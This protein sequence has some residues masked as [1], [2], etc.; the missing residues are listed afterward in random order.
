MTMTNLN[1]D[2]LEDVA[3]L[4]AEIVDEER[5]YLDSPRGKRDAARLD[6]EIDALVAEEEA[7][8]RRANLRRRGAVAAAEFRVEGVDPTTK[9]T[10]STV[11]VGNEPL[12]YGP[13]SDFSYFRDRFSAL[14]AVT[15]AIPSRNR[16][17][18]PQAVRD[19]LLRH[20]DQMSYL[21]AHGT[22]EERALL[23]GYF[24][25]RNRPFHGGPSDRSGED[26]RNLLTARFERRGISTL[27]ASMGDFAPTVFSLKDWAKYRTAGSPV[28]SQAGQSD[29]P[30]TGMT[31]DIPVMQGAVS[32][33]VQASENTA[34]DNSSPTVG[35]A[36]APVLTAAGVVELSQ[37]SLDRFGPGVRADEVIAAQAARQAAT[38]ID[39]QAVAAVFTSPAATITNSNSP[40]VGA[41]FA[42]VGKAK[43]IISTTEGVR[44][45]AT[46]VMI[47]PSNMAWFQSQLDGQQRP[48][49]GPSPAATLGHVGKANARDEGYQGYDV[50]GAETFGDANLG[51]SAGFANVLVGDLP[52]GLLVLTGSPVVD[53]W[54]QFQP[55]SLTAIVTI[56]Q[57]F[58]LAVLYPNAFVKITGAAYPVTPTFTGS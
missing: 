23:R 58:A 4:M 38:T 43:S 22:D 50:L 54:P 51:A 47:P 40:R 29:L 11:K 27:T 14:Q 34:V 9:H 46:H 1:R 53:V 56:R 37:Q 41:L 44:L 5:R 6:A 7:E 15:P 55:T 36:A 21:A 57:Y 19:R 8:A 31:V 39:T 2:D 25:K 26:F 12:V 49:W 33:D 20:Q 45:D 16:A 30:A 42:D 17:D 24:R 32:M 48:I 52:N 10:G 28:A 13:G 18:T 35:Y 3:G